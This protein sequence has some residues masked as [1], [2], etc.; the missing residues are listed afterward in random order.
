MKKNKNRQ[1]GT[2]VLY[3]V[4]ILSAVAILA[5]ASI[6]NLL[7]SSKLIK[8]LDNSA[9][10]REM[11]FAGLETAKGV[12][13]DLQNSNFENTIIEHKFYNGSLSVIIKLNPESKI[14]QITSIGQSKKTK[15]VLS[16]ELYQ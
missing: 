12:L 6:H 14:Y 8:R 5:T 4:I 7:Q 10:A 16:E 2:A 15:V 9:V 11:A 1:K 13:N 3:V